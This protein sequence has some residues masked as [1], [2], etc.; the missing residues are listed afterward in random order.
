MSQEIQF[1]LI[2]TTI[3][4]LIGLVGFFWRRSKSLEDTAVVTAIKGMHG[5]V[6]DTKE[7]IKQLSIRTDLAFRAGEKRMDD[8]SHDITE[9]QTRCNIF[10]GTERK[11]G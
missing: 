4:A 6:E 8:M 3:I 5:T 2:T 1:W 7:S 11:V 10:H 9:I